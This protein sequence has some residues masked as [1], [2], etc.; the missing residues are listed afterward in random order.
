ME[1]KKRASPLAVYDFTYSKEKFDEK[2]KT[3]KDFETVLKTWFK[4]WAYQ[5]E[6][7][8]SGN[9]HYQGRASLK[10]K[11]RP[12]GMKNTANEIMPGSHFS[13]TPKDVALVGDLFYVIKH[14]TRIEGPW[15]SANK[16]VCMSRQLDITP[17]PW[18]KSILATG[19]VCQNYVIN[20]MIDPKGG[21]GKSTLVEYARCK[22]GYWEAPVSGNS[23]KIIASVYKM[24][25]T[26]KC[27][28]PKLIFF[29]VPHSYHKKKLNDLLCAIESVKDGYA[30]DSRYCSREWSF[31]PPTI[32]VFANFMIDL[33]LVSLG[34]WKFWQVDLKTKDLRR[35]EVL[36]PTERSSTR[37][38]CAAPGPKEACTSP[39]K[40]ARFM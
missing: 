32:W 33:S 3:Q 20:I 38:A 30:Y 10:K 29:D 40:R 11:Q 7:C 14:G 31:N 35:L 26:A 6:E 27:R 12:T 23:K 4:Q 2:F 16:E 28:D 8:K 19:L 18:Q 9:V 21:I 36:A 5:L 34:K 37:A 15:T 17:W 39:Q 1:K 13:P 22:H 25:S 24:L